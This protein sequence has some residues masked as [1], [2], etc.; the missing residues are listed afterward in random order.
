MHNDRDILEERLRLAPRGL[1][2]RREPAGT[3]V[4][5]RDRRTDDDGDAR[6]R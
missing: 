5:E 4:R 2:R 3:R 1:D 6:K